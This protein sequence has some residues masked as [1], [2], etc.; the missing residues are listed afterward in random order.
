MRQNIKDKK[1]LFNTNQPT[2]AGTISGTFPNTKEKNQFQRK[3]FKQWSKMLENEY[4]FTDI[5]ENDKVD[6]VMV[7]LN[8][9][10]LHYISFVI[11]AINSSK[12]SAPSPS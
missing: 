1:K 4:M 2:A 3:T 7:S 8:I 6:Y 10:L 12:L 5:I 9:Q 11:S